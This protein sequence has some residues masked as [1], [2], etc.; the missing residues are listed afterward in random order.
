MGKKNTTNDFYEEVVAANDGITKKDV[1]KLFIWYDLLGYSLPFQLIFILVYA[2]G[3]NKYWIT[4][5]SVI[6][7]FIVDALLKSSLEKDGKN[8]VKFS[9]HISLVKLWVIPLVIMGILTTA[10]LL[11][12]N[13][14]LI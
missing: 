5:F 12:V 8:Y 3:A 6:F 11:A 10:S 1:K 9:K 7:I 2:I 14:G 13:L 4:M